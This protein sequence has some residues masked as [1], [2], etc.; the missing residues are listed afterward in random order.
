MAKSARKSALR[1]AELLRQDPIAYIE[2][3][4]KHRDGG[5][6]EPFTDKFGEVV[7]LLY[8]LAEHLTA[9]ENLGN[10]CGCASHGLGLLAI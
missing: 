10:C 9:S 4:G 6:R 1:N 7:W 2:P 5:C 3:L 8:C